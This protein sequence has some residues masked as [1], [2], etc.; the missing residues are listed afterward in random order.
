L[1]NSSSGSEKLNKREKSRGGEHRNREKRQE[2]VPWF[3]LNEI[4]VT[5]PI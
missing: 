3:Y 2:G 5:G 1:K 4:P